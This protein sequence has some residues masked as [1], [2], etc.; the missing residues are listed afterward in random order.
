MGTPPYTANDHAMLVRCISAPRSRQNG[1]SKILEEGHLN[2][3]LPE[4]YILL[5]TVPGGS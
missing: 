2:K 3:I 4:D 5:I 1:C